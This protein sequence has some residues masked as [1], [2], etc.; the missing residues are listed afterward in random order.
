MSAV[1]RLQFGVTIP[2]AELSNMTP[3]TFDVDRVSVVPEPAS[4]LLAAVGGCRRH[5]LGGHEETIRV[6][7]SEL[8]EN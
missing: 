4:L 7:R 5:F 1:A 2:D 6:S 8:C 3:I